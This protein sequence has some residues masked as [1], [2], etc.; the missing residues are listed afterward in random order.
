MITLANFS[1]KTIIGGLSLLLILASPLS[2]PAFERS[3][4]DAGTVCYFWVNRNVIFS[5]NKNCSQDVDKTACIQAVQDSLAA[6]TGPSCSDLVLTYA[7]TTTQTSIGMDCLNLIVWRQ[8]NDWNYDKSA[9][10][11]T[12]T[13]FSKVSGQIFDA[14]IEL[15]GVDYI[16]ATSGASN[17]MDIQNTLTHE[18]GHC[19]GLADL[20]D[21]ADSTETMFFNADYGDINKRTLSP[22][23]INGLCTIYP[24]GMKTPLCIGQ[25]EISSVGDCS[26]SGGGCATTA[27]SSENIFTFTFLAL[28]LW[29]SRKY[30]R[31][32]TLG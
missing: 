29:L 10:A 12:T 20:I 30:F 6:W 9:I 4:N 23:D 18:L 8:S 22:D 5:I 24:V 32:V 25:Q 31:R 14:D 21:T 16:F 17:A 19:I 13:T 27:V 7:G 28:L 1:R 15:N 2:S 3:Q 26:S 11:M